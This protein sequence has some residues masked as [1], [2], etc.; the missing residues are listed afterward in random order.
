L[1][2]LPI[3]TLTPITHPNDH[4]PGPIRRLAD[5]G[6]R[7]DNHTSSRRAV[8]SMT[9]DGAMP[10]CRTRMRAKR[11]AMHRRANLHKFTERMDR[12]QNSDMG[13]HA[14]SK[15]LLT[16]QAQPRSNEMVAYFRLSKNARCIGPASSSEASPDL[17]AHPA[18][19][20]PNALGQRGNISQRR[21]RRLFE[22]CR[23]AIPPV[24]VRR[25]SN[26][27]R[28]PA[29]ELELLHAIVRAFGKRHCIV[30]AQRPNG[31]AQIRPTPRGTNDIAVVKYQ[32]L[33]GPALTGLRSRERSRHI[34]SL[35]ASDVGPL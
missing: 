2:S 16:R 3:L 10:H 5:H 18:T 22:E 15:R 13:G 32:T 21:Q 24:A 14:G 34:D 27:E 8:G 30:K 23:C 20:R 31:D 35:V 28:C 1:Q 25:E 9:A 7:I 19:D 26:S 29:A 17:L 4:R 33:T 11:V 12:A 6:K